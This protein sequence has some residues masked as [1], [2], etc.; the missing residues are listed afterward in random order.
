VCIARIV[1]LVEDIDRLADEGKQ[2]KAIPAVPKRRIG[3]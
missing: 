1:V 2:M 3:F